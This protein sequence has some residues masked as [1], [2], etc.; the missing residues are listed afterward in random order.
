MQTDG[1]SVNFLGI[2]GAKLRQILNYGENAFAGCIICKHDR[3]QMRKGGIF[4]NFKIRLFGSRVF[5]V[6]SGGFTEKTLF[7]DRESVKGSFGRG[8]WMWKSWACESVPAFLF[9]KG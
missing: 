7:G 4:C 9:L 1:F 3:E 5:W 2:E 6:E 8:G